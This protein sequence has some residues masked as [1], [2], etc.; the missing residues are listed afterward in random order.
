MGS[1]LI[2]LTIELERLKVDESKKHLQRTTI[3]DPRFKLHCFN[4]EIQAD[5]KK[6]CQMFFN[7][8]KMV[9]VGM[10]AKKPS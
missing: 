1:W 9:Q 8:S 7:S 5:M 2:D 4:E 3:L 6:D 10:Q